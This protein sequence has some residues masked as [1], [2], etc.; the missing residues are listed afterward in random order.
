MHRSP[1]MKSVLSTTMMLLTLVFLGVS[2][3]AT[4]TSTTHIWSAPVQ[5]AVAPQNVI[6]FGG[7]MTE[8]TRRTVEET[9]VRELATRGVRA[10]PSYRIFPQLP[11]RDIAQ[12][13]V[14]KLGFDGAVVATLRQVRERQSY[15]PGHYYGGFWGGYYGSGWGMG[16]WSP[17]Y[18][19][20]DEYVIVETTYWNL[21][22]H[23]GDL[24]WAINTQTR[25]PDSTQDFVDS[26]IEE[27]ME[28]LERT[29][30]VR[31]R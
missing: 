18:V 16:S 5:P 26:Y 28:N 15:V 22:N 20:T 9:F 29:P 19:V 11:T 10:T 14:K 13:E 27:V 21:R 24:V 4:P 8:P 6:V 23:D 2:G 1:S 3:C 25:N 12:D 31:K 7:R 30:L 17:G